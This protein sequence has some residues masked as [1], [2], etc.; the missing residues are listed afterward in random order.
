MEEKI[1]V[2][3]TER[4]PNIWLAILCSVAIALVGCVL[5]GL[6]YYAGYIA[7]IAA[8]LVVVGSAWGYKKFNQKMDLKGWLIVSIVSIAGILASMFIALAVYVGKEF[9][10]SIGEAFDQLWN[11]IKTNDSIESA[12]IRDGVLTAVCIVLGLVTYFFYERKLAKNNAKSAEIL[13]N[14]TKET[15]N[16]DAVVEVKN[17]DNS[18]NNVE[19][20]EK[21]LEGKSPKKTKNSDDKKSE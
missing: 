11:L 7:Y 19:D 10:L 21:Q 4:K 6:L 18:E 1:R 20:I 2:T 17:T 3:K 14:Q 5:Y 8:Y 16:S 9:G 12:V 13:N 15:N